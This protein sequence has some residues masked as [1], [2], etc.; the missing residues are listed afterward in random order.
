MLPLIN[1]PQPTTPPADTRT[2]PNASFTNLRNK[3][4]AEIDGD[5]DG[6]DE[7]HDWWLS[8]NNL[9]LNAVALDNAYGGVLAITSGYRCPAGN[10]RVGSP[11][12][13]SKHTRGKALDYDQ[14]DS[15][16]NWLVLDTADNRGFSGY[17]HGSN[18]VDY[19]WSPTLWPPPANVDYE[20]GHIQW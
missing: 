10:K 9:I 2:P 12:P 18:E 16:Q 8:G 17:V 1:H 3:G 4:V 14:L 11:S 5:N 7:R 20:R 6:V 19:W 13:N 15:F